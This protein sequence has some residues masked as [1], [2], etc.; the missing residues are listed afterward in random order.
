V[1]DV[2]ESCVL[3]TVILDQ[4]NPTW[5]AAITVDYMFEIT[6]EVRAVSRL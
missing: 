3:Q 4:L 2:G 1:N 5:A 6:Q